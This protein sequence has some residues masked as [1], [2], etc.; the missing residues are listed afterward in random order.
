MRGAV[1]EREGAGRCRREEAWPRGRAG[2]AGKR[3]A[4][5]RNAGT[6]ELGRSSFARS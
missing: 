3:G 6:R 5:V 2:E 1:V 4:N